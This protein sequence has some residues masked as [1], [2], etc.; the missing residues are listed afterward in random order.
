M[1]DITRLGAGAGALAGV[2]LV[3]AFGSYVAAPTIAER[4][5]IKGGEIERCAVAIKANVTHAT[6]AAIAAVP[7]PRQMPDTGAALRQAMGAIF[8]G[9][10]GGGAYMERYGGQFEQWGRSIGAPLRAQADAA[11][12]EYEAVVS[13]VR[14]MGE[15]NANA[16]GDV[17]TCRARAVINSSEGRSGVAWHVGSLGFISDLPV[18]DWQ[19]A[20]RRPEIVAQCETRS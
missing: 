8:G 18:S 3:W 9:H 1:F 5:V 13:R 2:G 19:S 20:M 10:P 11:R 12:E 16:S 7:K 6:E 17:C 14:Q 15:L 4:L